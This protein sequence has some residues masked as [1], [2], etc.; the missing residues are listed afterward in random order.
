MAYHT[1][2]TAQ[3]VCHHCSYRSGLI[4]LCPSCSGPT[5]HEV[6]IGIQRVESDL[7]RHFP[8]RCILRVDSDGDIEKTRI[9][10]TLE[11]H[12]IILATYAGLSLLHVESIEVIVF[13]LFES[14]LTLPDY[15]MEEDLYHALEYAKKS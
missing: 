4:D 12:D 8:E 5:F 11:D 15:R 2:P 10:E 3:L 14:E 13:L 7:A 1:F 6:G 9:I